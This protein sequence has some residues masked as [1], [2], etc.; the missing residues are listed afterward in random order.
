MRGYGRMSGIANR[1]DMP[2]L[3]IESAIGP[4][5]NDIENVI[6]ACHLLV[7]V[8]ITSVNRMPGDP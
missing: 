6:D 7:L 4:V 8:H 1:R 5:A 2:L 3:P